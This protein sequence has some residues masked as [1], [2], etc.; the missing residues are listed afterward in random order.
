MT[1]I[2]FISITFSVILV[3]FTRRGISAIKIPGDLVV[4]YCLVLYS[5]AGQDVFRAYE[6]QECFAGIERELIRLQE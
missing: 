6:R 4:N 2:Q 3:D 5:C 1:A